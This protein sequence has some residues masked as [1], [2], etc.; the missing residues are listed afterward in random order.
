MC[1]VFPPASPVRHRGRSPGAMGIRRRANRLTFA[2]S[3]SSLLAMGSPDDDIDVGRLGS[4]DVDRHP[5][6]AIAPYAGP[7][8]WTRDLA[9]RIKRLRNTKRLSQRQLATR[10]GVNVTYLNKIENG[11]QTG[12]EEVLRKLAHALEVPVTELLVLTTHVPEEI[13]SMVNPEVSPAER[14]TVLPDFPHPIGPP[15]Y[16]TNFVNR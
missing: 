3:L 12:S 14:P 5:D 11:R 1:Q 15:R 2:P 9:A 6:P 4:T 7:E 16:T 10:A 13:K 8:S